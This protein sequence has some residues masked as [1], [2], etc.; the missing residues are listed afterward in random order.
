MLAKVLAN[1]LYLPVFI[2]IFVVQT[3]NSEF[4]NVYACLLVAK[5]CVFSIVVLQNWVF[6]LRP[7]QISI[8]NHLLCILDSALMTSDQFTNGVMTQVLFSH[9][10]SQSSG[11]L[12]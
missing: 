4:L 8:H 1:S 6:Q 7:C 10:A 5:M 2:C 3:N 11:T 9:L 12:Q